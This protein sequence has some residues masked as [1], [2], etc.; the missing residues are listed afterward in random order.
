ME[1]LPIGHLEAEFD[2]LVGEDQKIHV[3]GEIAA[4]KRI[5]ET[6]RER[7]REHRFRDLLN[8]LPAAIYTTDA[9]GRITY[10]NEAAAEMWGVR[11]EL[12][13]AEWCGSWK[14]I[15]RTERRWRTISAR[16]RW[17]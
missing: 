17:R 10:F 14:S 15:G 7:E 13:T 6:E 16:W 3:L 1:Q 9:A 5:A 2:K 12:G 8:V 11:P 4:R